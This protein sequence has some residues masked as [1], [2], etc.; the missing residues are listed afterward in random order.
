MANPKLSSGI[1]KTQKLPAM[2]IAIRQAHCKESLLQTFPVHNTVQVQILTPQVKACKVF[3]KKTL[4]VDICVICDRSIVHRY[5]H[6]VV[7][8]L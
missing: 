4:S 5:Q 2:E 1:A 8:E 6:S 3:G 7:L